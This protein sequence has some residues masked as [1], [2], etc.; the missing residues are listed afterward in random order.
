MKACDYV[1]GLRTKELESCKR[2]IFETFLL[3]EKQKRAVRLDTETHYE[4][5]K[6]LSAEAGVGDQEA[7]DVVMELL[8]CARTGKPFPDKVTEVLD[9]ERGTSEDDESSKANGKKAGVKAAKTKSGKSP[10]ATSKASKPKKSKKDDDDDILDDDDDEPKPRGT[11]KSNEEDAD[12]VHE[13]RETTH[14]LIKQIRTAVGRI[15]SLR[16]FKAVRDIQSQHKDFKIDCVGCGRTDISR[17][18]AS[19]FSACGHIGCTDCIKRCARDQQCIVGRAKCAAEV[20]SLNVVS[21]AVMGVDDGIK[22]AKRHFGKK[23]EA[24]VDLIR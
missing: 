8:D 14:V 9:T 17:E 18:D 2:S 13:H 15:R 12:L 10:K 4:R 11:K 1:V 6:R 20:S 5:W 16:Y 22:D 24:V 21:A 23:L 3:L 19:L 7:T